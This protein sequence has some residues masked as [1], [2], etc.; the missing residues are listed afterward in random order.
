LVALKQTVINGS[1][2]HT[3]EGHVVILTAE[4]VGRSSDIQI[5]E[6]QH[7]TICGSGHKAAI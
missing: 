1:Y 6:W 3:P 2:W 7:F 4:A 5:A